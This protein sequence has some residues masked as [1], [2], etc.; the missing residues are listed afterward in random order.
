MT[1]LV[2]LGE[3]GVGTMPAVVGGREAG[4]IPLADR[5]QHRLPPPAHTIN[6]AGGAEAIRPHRPLRV[7]IAAAAIRVEGVSEAEDTQTVAGG[8]G[9]VAT[10]AVVAFAVAVRTVV[11]AAAVAATDKGPLLSPM[12]ALCALFRLE[13]LF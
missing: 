12:F 2:A 9:Q 5:R 3:E 6:T 11:G 1:H 7:E 10:V 4:G 8:A 13:W